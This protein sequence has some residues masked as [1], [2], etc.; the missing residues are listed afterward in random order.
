MHVDPMAAFAGAL[1][2]EACGGQPS[3]QFLPRHSNE[4]NLLLGYI[5]GLPHDIQLSGLSARGPLGGG[6]AIFGAC[7]RGEKFNCKYVAHT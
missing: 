4:Y 1:F 3:D 5:E 6:S 2:H 7:R